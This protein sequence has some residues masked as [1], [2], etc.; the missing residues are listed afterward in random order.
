MAS[1]IDII[2]KYKN[3]ISELNKDK[4]FRKLYSYDK[5]FLD[6]S[7][8]DYLNLSNNENVIAA[9]YEAAK[10]YGAGSSGSRLL[11]GN[12]PIF[13]EFESQIAM[14][15]N[16]E[17]AIIFNSGFQ[18]NLGALSVLLDKDSTVIFDK[19]N[20]ASMY[21]GAF[22]S[23]A[24]L[25]RYNHLNYDQLESILKENENKNV[26]IATETV[27][28]MDGDMADLKALSFLSE[29]Y[30]A[31]LYL[32]EAHATGLY[33][34]FGYGL[35]TNFN[36]N[37]ERTIIMGTFSKALG[38]SGAYIASSNII[39]DYLIQK[40]KSFIYS[41]AISPFC[42]GAAQHSWNLI[43]NLGEVREKLMR[44]SQYI[45]DN[46]KDLGYKVIG[47]KT[48]IIPIIFEN[49]E[50]VEAIRNRFLKEKIIVSLIRSPTSPTPRIR[51]ALSASHSK[52]HLRK[53]LSVLEE[54]YS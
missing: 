46:I 2:E 4:L 17:S 21:Q 30:N 33:G 53:A 37:M 43:R 34:K 38:V 7:S 52:N 39:I 44:D 45:R 31:I 29:K 22:I 16:A 27:F 6:F 50:E 26:F 20:H 11:S 36:L 8:N 18:A 13:E 54:A 41:T 10:K 5:A 42:I 49:I 35:S 24:K 40:C 19:L 51:I 47:N 23:N 15:K 25:I 48:N 32:D 3:I 12:K 14:D 1:Q 9:G 28:G